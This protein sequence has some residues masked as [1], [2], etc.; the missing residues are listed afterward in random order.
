[1]LELYLLRHGKAARPENYAKDFERP[2]NKKGVAQLNQLGYRLRAEEI[3]IS[4]LISSSAQRTKETAIIANHF[5]TIPDVSYEKE[6]YLADH[7]TIRKFICY[8]AKKPSLLYVGH[9]FGISDLCSY[10]SGESISMSTG[11]LVKL[12]FDFDD[13]S[14]I[15]ADTGKVEWIYESDVYIP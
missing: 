10:L 15:S 1:M 11:M 5:L 2:L 13:W 8:A 9:N 7:E 12:N 4:Q 3:K 14:L 6:L